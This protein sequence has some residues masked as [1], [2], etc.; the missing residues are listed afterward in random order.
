MIWALKNFRATN[1]LLVDWTIYQLAP[2]RED[3]RLS[4]RYD[5]RFQLFT[6]AQW[7]ACRS[8]LEF[9]LHEDPE[10][11]II[12]AVV[13]KQALAEVEAKI[14]GEQFATGNRP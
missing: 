5:S 13:A 3:K 11:D 1:E 6:S 12:D 4:G 10:G 2:N 9:L 7:C 8:F 14:N